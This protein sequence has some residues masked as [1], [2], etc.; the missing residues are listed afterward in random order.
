MYI[1]DNDDQA[2]FSTYISYLASFQQQQRGLKT[3]LSS[4][5][6]SGYIFAGVDENLYNCVFVANPTDDEAFINELIELK[7][8]QN[9]LPLTVW[10]TINTTS[11]TIDDSL[12]KQFFSPG[13]FFGMVLD[14]E[15][16]NVKPV[17]PGITIERV[18]SPAQ[19]EKFSELFCRNFNF[20]NMRQRM[21]EYMIY[22]GQIA[23]PDC[24][25]YLARYEG[26]YVGTSSLMLDKQFNLFATGGLYNA[27]VDENYRQLGVGYAMA[28]HRIQVAKELNLKKLS[29]I[30]MSDAM[31]RGYCQRLGFKAISTFTPYII[32]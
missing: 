27:C 25:N 9:N 23:E 15:Q 6:G 1:S 21:T 29:I 31:A 24:L 8:T 18:I 28:A 14:L 16:A 10:T 20:K 7:A 11:H 30:L 13:A 2:A 26:E 19:A 32:E 5:P 12:S 3:P 22:Q 17:K 4:D